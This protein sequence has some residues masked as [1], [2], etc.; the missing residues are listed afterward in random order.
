MKVTA[1]G[2]VPHKMR[3]RLQIAALAGNMN[4]NM[5]INA[6]SVA[7]L[8]IGLKIHWHAALTKQSGRDINLITVV[9][10]CLE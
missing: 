5:G 9:P 2:D 4:K 1:T 8:E 10:A 7:A 6:V 3:P